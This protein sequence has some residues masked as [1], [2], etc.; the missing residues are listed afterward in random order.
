VATA[1]E[2]T[3]F[4]QQGKTVAATCANEFNF[5]LRPLP[6]RGSRQAVAGVRSAELERTRFCPQGKTVAAT[7]ANEFNFISRPLPARGS[8]RDARI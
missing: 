8:R 7:C 3:R 2:R 4:C 6:V 1:L 5:I